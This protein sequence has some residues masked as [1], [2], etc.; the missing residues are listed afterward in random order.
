M[1]INLSVH[2]L[3]VIREKGKKEIYHCSQCF[4]GAKLGKQKEEEKHLEKPSR[5]EPYTFPSYRG[6]SIY[7]PVQF[8]EFNF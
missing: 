4:C 5:A 2:F 7:I 8:F 3:P 6:E 1:V